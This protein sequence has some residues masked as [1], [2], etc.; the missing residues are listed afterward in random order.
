METALRERLEKSLS[1]EEA[2]YVYVDTVNNAFIAAQIKALREDRNLSQ[3][4][5]A[6]LLGTQQSGVSRLERPD[7]AAW[8]VE[9]LRKLAR[10][11]GVRVRIRF[12]EFSSLLDEIGGFDDK[13]LIPRKFEDDPVFG[14]GSGRSRRP[15]TRR[16]ITF[17]APKKRSKYLRKPPMRE[18]A[19]P[20]NQTLST[21]QHRSANDA[22]PST[23]SSIGA[24]STSPITLG[25]QYGR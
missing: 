3:E 2:R 11:F 5:L 24:N 8:K 20:Y 10:A 22:Q 25:A 6:E 17:S 19:I 23:H 9:T 21:A 18:T 7:Y 13:N 4:Q 16:K 14:S 15:R 12:E 1:G